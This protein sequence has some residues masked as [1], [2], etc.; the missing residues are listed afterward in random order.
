M[1]VSDA[2]SAGRVLYLFIALS[3]PAL[4]T[5][6]TASAATSSDAENIRSS[7]PVNPEST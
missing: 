5:I 2:S 4:S 1:V 7:S 6:F 3:I